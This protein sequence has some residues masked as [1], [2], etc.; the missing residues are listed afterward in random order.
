MSKKFGDLELLGQMVDSCLVE[1][2]GDDGMAKEM[3]G[4]IVEYI[5]RDRSQ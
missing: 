4:S 2:M 3:Y 5:R 1:H